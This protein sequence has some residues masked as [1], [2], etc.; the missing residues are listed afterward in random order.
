MR[1]KLSLGNMIWAGSIWVAVWV[2]VALW[3]CSMYCGCTQPT[4][5]VASQDERLKGI[6]TSGSDTVWLDGRHAWETDADELLVRT[7]PP[8]RGFFEV[9]T[10]GSIVICWVNSRMIDGLEC[11]GYVKMNIAF[12][13]MVSGLGNNGGTN[14]IVRTANELIKMGH[15]VDILARVDYFNKVSHRPCIDRVDR[16]EY[17]A[18]IGVS[19]MDIQNMHKQF[20]LGYEEKKYWWMRLWDSER[21]GWT[22]VT[23]LAMMQPTFVNGEWMQKE[24]ENHGVKSKLLR[25]GVDSDY[26]VPDESKRI[27]LRVGS[28][29]RPEPRKC[30]GD[31]RLL[32]GIWKAASFNSVRDLSPED[33]RS[34]YQSLE[35]FLAPARLEGCP[36]TV[37]EAAL[38]GCKVIARRQKEAGVAELLGDN[39]CYLYDD[40]REVPEMVA[41]REVDTAR[42]RFEIMGIGTRKQCAE[43]LVYYI[44]Q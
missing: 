35:Y 34:W 15:D 5:P 12:Y 25:Q 11:K 14:T 39:A 13:A 42:A 6:W 3:L 33:L 27:P 16:V 29:Y 43:Q 23:Q 37:L 1:I 4:S 19:Y 30:Q 24:L 36:N 21:I 17:D 9:R 44:S 18:V 10:D 31:F 40:I 41:S 20:L 28:C 26:W 32:E 7:E 38:C 22:G 2:F 8:R